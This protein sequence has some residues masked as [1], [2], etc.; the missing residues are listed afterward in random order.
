MPVDGRLEVEGEGSD[1]AGTP[2][3]VPGAPVEGIDAP[4]L[5]AG[6]PTV[7]VEPESPPP[8]SGTPPPPLVLAQAARVA[9]SARPIQL[10]ASR[11]MAWSPW[12]RS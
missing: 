9:V 3:V 12:P 10:F 4:P 6:N 7:G 1:G 2:A 11:I 5:G 8:F